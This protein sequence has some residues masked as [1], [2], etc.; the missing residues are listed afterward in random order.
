MPILSVLQTTPLYINGASGIRLHR[1]GL[2]RSHRRGALPAATGEATHARGS[3]PGQGA[4]ASEET[5]DEGATAR[6]A[7]RAHAYSNGNLYPMILPSSQ[8][9]G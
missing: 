2:H 7:L 3:P 5:A 6:H 9:I 8:D 1:G 4:S